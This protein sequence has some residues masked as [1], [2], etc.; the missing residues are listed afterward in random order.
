MLAG[1]CSGRFGQDKGLLLLM[2][3]PLVK[4]VLDAVE[5]LAE[6]RLVVVSSET[7]AANYQKIVGKNTRV[8]IDMGKIQAPLM[9]A[10]TGFEAARGDY[11]LL[12]P[13]DVPFVSSD[14]ARFL[15]DICMGKAAVVPRWPDGYI[16]PL[17]AVYH[18]ESAVEASASALDSGEL[19]MQAMIERLRGVRYVSSLVLQEI[20][21]ELRTFF[22]VNTQL[23]L[24]KAEGM[25]R[26]KR[27]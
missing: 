24:K 9:G 23:D 15:F 20:D 3:K 19:R 5:N 21:P 8:L 7:Q 2:N 25:L 17:Q 4:H 18:R 13:C 6:E 14:A 11:S 16:E 12:L 27:V 26:K 10:L 1:G 22:N